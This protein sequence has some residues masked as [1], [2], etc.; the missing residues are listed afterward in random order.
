MNIK[1][2]VKK[3]IE[4]VING[5]PKVIIQ[6]TTIINGEKIDTGNMSQEEK[7]KYAEDI[8]KKSK[9]AMRKAT[10]GMNKAFESLDEACEAFE[11]IL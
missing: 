9:V 3:V 6:R 11:G 5:A 10:E 1:K 2:T 8:E 4:S 7:V